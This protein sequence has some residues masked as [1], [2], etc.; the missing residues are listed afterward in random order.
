MKSP[1]E[2]TGGAIRAARTLH[3]Y[4][5]GGACH[6][7]NMSLSF[8]HDSPPVCPDRNVKDATM[9]IEA[10]LF[11]LII[12]LREYFSTGIPSSPEQGRFRS[13]MNF[14]VFYEMT[15]VALHSVTLATLDIKKPLIAHGVHIAW[16]ETDGLWRQEIRIFYAQQI[17]AF[18]FFFNK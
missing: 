13:F 1:Q 3:L 11:F 14:Q 4:V 12:A 9:W 18:F 6:V 7:Q 10:L 17:Y 15:T 8:N 5:W 16:G 2:V